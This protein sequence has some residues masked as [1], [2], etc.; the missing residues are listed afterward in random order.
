MAHITNHRIDA[1]PHPLRMGQVFRGAALVAALIYL[2][3]ISWYLLSHGGWPTPDYLIPPLLL[4]AIALGRGWA[5]VFDWG[6]FLILILSWQATAGIADQ[7]GRPVH[8]EQPA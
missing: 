2:L 8:V 1:R 5:F 3:G 4:L 7:L 6:P